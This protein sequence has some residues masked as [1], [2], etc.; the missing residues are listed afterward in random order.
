MALWMADKHLEF[1]MFK[2]ELLRPT[3]LPPT[4]YTH[5]KISS[6]PSLPQQTTCYI[7]HCLGPKPQNNLCSHSQIILSTLS[8]KY[9]LQIIQF[10]SMSNGFHLSPR[11]FVLSPEQLQQQS[12]NRSSTST[13]AP[14]I[15]FPQARPSSKNI[16]QHRSLLS[17]SPPMASYQSPNMTRAPHCGLKQPE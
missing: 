16:N 7:L 2:K 9:I 14:V 13:C 8:M 4:T 3:V 1:H 11:E 10:F 5:T 12:Y 17:Q 6:S 15:H